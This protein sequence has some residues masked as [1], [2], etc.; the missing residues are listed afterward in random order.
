[1]TDENAVPEVELGDELIQVVGIRIHVVAAPR[2]AR[3]A[4]ATAVMGNAAIAARGEIEHLVFESVSRQGPAVTEDDGLS[5]APVVV[6]DLG[7]VL[8]GECAHGAY[9]FT[10]V[11][12]GGG[13]G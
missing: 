12:R 6:V 5:A 8:G 3:A 1:M 4:V 11:R 13:L 9:S 7:A 10:R 2:L